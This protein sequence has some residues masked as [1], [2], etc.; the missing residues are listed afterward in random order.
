LKAIPLEPPLI[1]SA[2]INPTDLSPEENM[3]AI[4]RLCLSAI[5]IVLGVLDILHWQGTVG[6]L[7]MKMPAPSLMLACAIILKIGGGILLLTGQKIQLGAVALIVFMI[8][9]TLL[10]HNFWAAP[11]A[12]YQNQLIQF[13]KN[14]AIIGGLLMVLAPPKKS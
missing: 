7:A 9:A 12:E 1:F 10:F 5:F 2:K 4:G 3:N 14:L 11:A 8:P 6:Y 13:L